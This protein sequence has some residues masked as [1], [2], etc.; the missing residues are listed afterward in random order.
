[1]DT[2]CTNRFSTGLVAILHMLSKSQILGSYQIQTTVCDNRTDAVVRIISNMGITGCFIENVHILKNDKKF[3]K[4][5][6]HGILAAIW[7]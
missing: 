2:D 3:D 7:S 4:G 6:I 5:S 1:M